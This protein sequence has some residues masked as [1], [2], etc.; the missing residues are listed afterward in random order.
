MYT[1][2]TFI[3]PTAIRD[4]CEM[5]CE[6]IAGGGGAGM[7]ITPLYSDDNLTHYISS[8]LIDEQFSVVLSDPEMVFSLCEKYRI[9]IEKEQ[10]LFIMSQVDISDDTAQAAIDRLGLTLTNHNDL[11]HAQAVVE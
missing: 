2:K 1:H 6:Q 8:G 4:V 3:V 7:F 5:L 9:A 10:L 11:Q